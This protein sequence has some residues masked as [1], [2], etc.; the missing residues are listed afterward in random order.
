MAERRVIVNADDYGLSPGVS[1]GILEAVAV[2][3]VTSVSVIVT[4]PDLDEQLR[5]LATAPRRPSVGLHLDLTAGVPLAGPRA[6]PTLV[7]RRERFHRLPRLVTHALAGAIA[8]GD[9]EREM[10]CQL[11]R[12]QRHG[13]T[14]SHIDSHRHVHALPGIWSVVCRVA[15]QAGI[16]W[17]RRP[18]EPA[19][20][21]RPGRL[22]RLVLST[23]CR[24]ATWGGAG[25]AATHVRGIGM[26]GS[27]RFTA[28]LLA[29]L[30]ELPAGLTELVVHPGR[31]DAHLLML[32]SYREP[33]ERELEA[34][35]APAVRSR[36]TQG[37]L[38]LTDFRAA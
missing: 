10:T 36:L 32:D 8:A 24:T 20:S 18:V 9:V 2:G 15:A 30:E 37:D 5:W 3:V 22:K 29:V 31:P 34:L 16:R 14:V 12:L 4:T 28:E 17:V 35:L 27:R 11:E 23:A 26:D 6:V 19:F 38:A 33:R 21:R 13:L 7:G 25:A 1:A